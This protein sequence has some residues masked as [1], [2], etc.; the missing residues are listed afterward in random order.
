MTSSPITNP[1]INAIHSRRS[2]RGFKP[3]PLTDAQIE[4]LLK[5]GLAAPSGANKQ[6]YRIIVVRNQPLLRELETAVMEAYERENNTAYLQRLKVRGNKCFYDA[7]VVFFVAIDLA[8]DAN[9]NCPEISCGAL[10]ENICLAATSMGLGSIMVGFPHEPVFA[11]E[12]GEALNEKFLFPEGYTF[13]IT[14]CVGHP[15]RAEGNPHPINPEKVVYW[16]EPLQGSPRGAVLPQHR[17]GEG[18][19][20]HRR[21]QLRQQLRHR[22]QPGDDIAATLLREGPEGLDHARRHRRDADAVPLDGLLRGAV[23]AVARLQIAADVVGVGREGGG[24]GAGT[25]G[26]VAAH[27]TAQGLF[28]KIVLHLAAP[29]AGAVGVG[30]EVPRVVDDLAELP[31]VHQVPARLVQ[32]GAQLGAHLFAGI[33]KGVVAAQIGEHVEVGKDAA[34]PD[35]HPHRQRRPH[36]RGQVVGQQQMICCLHNVLRQIDLKAYQLESSIYRRSEQPMGKLRTFDQNTVRSR[37]VLC[38]IQNSL[39]K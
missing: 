5:A 10:A 39:S 23:D 17:D 15:L 34:K 20:Q 16:T 37:L 14:V 18:V 30:K 26:Q 38:S 35:R 9:F 13:G 31:D 6:A 2:V 11:R 25:L 27:F 1:V 28:V 36:P 19:L 4:T 8:E 21:Q 32:Q 33:F 7:P 3:D 12:G 24:L 22:L 29:V